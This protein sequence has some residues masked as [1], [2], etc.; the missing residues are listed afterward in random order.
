MQKK[1]FKGV[2]WAVLIA[3]A[4]YLLITSVADIS[5]PLAGGIAVILGVVLAQIISERSSS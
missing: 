3:I 5:Y 4:A 1:S 2:L